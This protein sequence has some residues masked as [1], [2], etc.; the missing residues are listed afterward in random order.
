MSTEEWVSR[1]MSEVV[2]N[3]ALAV[4]DGQATLDRRTAEVQRELEAAVDAGELDYALDAPWYRFADVNVDVELAVG[5]ETREERDAEG[6]VRGYKPYVTAAPLSPGAARTY[7]VDA[8]LASTLSL[9]LVPVPPERRA[10]GA[11]PEGG[12]E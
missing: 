1:P 3:V 7:D 8:D 12:D 2:R 10:A 6:R 11:T 9:R 4:A 5:I